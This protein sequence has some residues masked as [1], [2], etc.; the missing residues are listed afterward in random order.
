[1]QMFKES[2]K[3]SA[4][5]IENKKV[6]VQETVQETDTKLAKGLLLSISAW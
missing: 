2:L 3:D 6:S 5:A 4:M 1:M